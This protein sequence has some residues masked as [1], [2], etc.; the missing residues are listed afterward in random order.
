MV[1]LTVNEPVLVG[2]MIGRASLSP[3]L[4]AVAVLAPKDGEQPAQNRKRKALKTYKNA[5]K[6]FRPSRATKE[7][8]WAA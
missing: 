3:V 8:K 2:V 4:L 6:V 1:D 5:G 7:L